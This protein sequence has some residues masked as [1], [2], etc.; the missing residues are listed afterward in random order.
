LTKRALK[1]TRPS[2]EGWTLEETGER[3]SKMARRR[4]KS[5]EETFLDP[6]RGSTHGPLAALIQASLE[7]SGPAPLVDLEG[8]ST[9]GYIKASRKAMSDSLTG[10]G[11]S[12]DTVDP[13][14]LK[15][16]APDK[17]GKRNKPRQKFKRGS[18]TINQQRSVSHSNVGNLLA[19]GFGDFGKAP[20]AQG[21]RFS[22]DIT[23]SMQD[24]L[25]YSDESA[26]ARA[27]LEMGRT[28][29]GFKPESVPKPHKSK[30]KA[31]TAT[32]RANA[33]AHHVMTEE[34]LR[35]VD[36]GEKGGTK[37][38]ERHQPAL[39]GIAWGL[40]SVASGGSKLE[41]VLGKSAP[42]GPTTPK[43]ISNQPDEFEDRFSSVLEARQKEAAKSPAIKALFGT[44]PVDPKLLVP[45][46]QAIRLDLRKA[47]GGESDSSD[48]EGY[49]TDQ[50]DEEEYEST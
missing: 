8:V 9:Q 16:G 10:Q 33:L 28:G 27:L 37:S 47:A 46:R 42:L 6:S 4:S 12:L 7:S 22:L 49:R 17:H 1:E 30:P 34:P 35:F 21:K 18:S 44:N 32:N 3:A 40:Q 43:D 45:S 48:S 2:A 23:Q 19:S 36:R 29:T 26:V 31:R 50:P 11:Q 13:A 24:D 15:W 5:T 25:G 20:T 14:T 39:T 38:R 41:D